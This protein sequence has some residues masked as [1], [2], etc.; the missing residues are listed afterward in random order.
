MANNEVY[1]L[2]V[3]NVMEIQALL[4]AMIH[5]FGN[6][7]QHYYSATFVVD[8]NSMVPW[9]WKIKKWKRQKF[10]HLHVSNE[11]EKKIF[12]IQRKDIKWPWLIDPF[13]GDWWMLHSKPLKINP[14]NR[15]TKNKMSKNYFQL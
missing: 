4:M 3:M 13:T 14:K 8:P 7:D 12:S 10:N 5:Q 1:A 15:N 6:V 2:N 9:V 11:N